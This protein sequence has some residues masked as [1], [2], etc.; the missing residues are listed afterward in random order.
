[1]KQEIEIKL[2][3]D[4]IAEALFDLDNHEVA[5]VISK[6][7]QLFDKEYERRKS[8]GKPIWIFDL[9]HFML[10]VM[11]EADEH[12]KEFFRNAYAHH[13]YTEGL[14]PA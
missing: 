13:L 1:M 2:T 10:H 11:Q 3:T 4:Q 5:E 9:N 6:W 7:K 12:V 14:I 8:E